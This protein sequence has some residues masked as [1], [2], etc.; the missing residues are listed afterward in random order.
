MDSSFD[1]KDGSIVKQTRTIK[2]PFDDTYRRL[3]RP[4]QAKATGTVPVRRYRT[5]NLP[6][7]RWI[8][9]VRVRKERV[10]ESHLVKRTSMVYGSDGNLE[11]MRETSFHERN[12]KPI[13]EYR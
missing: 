2:L 1:S 10:G 13:H 8:E 3:M 11:F 4:I 7:G 5:F 6:N 12:G 9:S